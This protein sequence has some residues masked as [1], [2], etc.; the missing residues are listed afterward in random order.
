M[1]FLAT[2]IFLSLCFQSNAQE[3]INW[4]GFSINPKHF[5]ARQ[6]SFNMIIDGKKVGSWRWHVSRSTD[7]LIFKDISILDDA[8]EEQ[9]TFEVSGDAFDRFKISLW[10]QTAN[11]R[12]ENE[13]NW[14]TQKAKGRFYQKRGEHERTISIDTAYAEA[15]P[16]GIF[17]AMLPAF[18]F[19]L[20][21]KKSLEFYSALG[22]SVW[23]INFSIVEITNVAVPAGTFETYKVQAL[24]AGR[25]GVSNVF[26]VTKK[27]PRRIVK[28]DVLEQNMSI[29]LIES[30][31]DKL[32]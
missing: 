16:R 26:Y 3:N 28:V 17:I 14:N 21:E 12:I 22:N 31:V 1:N 6:D 4:N 11:G 32:N 2:V 13:L 27:N 29:E 30:K 25:A 9:A 18:D 23:P 5:Q 7:V 10:L 15:I 8:V 24:K 20:G 19:K